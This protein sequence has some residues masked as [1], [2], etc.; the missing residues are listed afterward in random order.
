MA[1]FT[2]FGAQGLRGLAL[3][4][5]AVVPAVAQTTGV[6]SGTAVDQSGAVL[7]GASITA[8]HTPT[9]TTYTSVTDA[10]GR[11]EIP[12]V[13]VGGPYSVTAGLSGF[14]DQ[15]QQGL[16][17]KLGDEAHVSFKLEVQAVAE[18][19]T[20][21][22]EANPLI[23]PGR[24]GAAANV[25]KET[26][27]SLP[28]LNRSLNDF[29]RLS[30]YFNTD[31]GQGG[32]TVAGKNYRYNNIQIDGAVDNDLF[33]LASSGTPGGQAGTNPI[34]LDAIQEV[35][36]VVAPYDVRLGGFTGGGINAVTRSGS[37]SV[38]GTG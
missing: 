5:L 21:T 33:G 32:L 35:Q 12:N 28:T 23:N 36:L 38:H 24:T 3:A 26:I 14:K 4:L 37:N 25:Y 16:S 17:V 18:T 34:S 10:Q 9:G 22:A 27:E 30:P 31:E 11:F 19:V 8:V 7:P 6:L 13:R 1:R 15:V 20:V 2:P 29:A